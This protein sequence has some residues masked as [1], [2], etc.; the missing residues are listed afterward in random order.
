[1]D[2][3]CGRSVG[4][5][6]TQHSSRTIMLVNGARE[7]W[8]NTGTIAVAPQLQTLDIIKVLREMLSF[9][10]RLYPQRRQGSDE[11][12]FSKYR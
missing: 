8:H 11:T 1:M 3:P 10:R 9:W 5:A 4:Y 6:R 7:I 12:A 2:V